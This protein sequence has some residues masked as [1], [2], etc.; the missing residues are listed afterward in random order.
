MGK[1]LD[2]LTLTQ[3]ASISGS[4][5]SDESR[6]DNGAKL[7]VHSITDRFSVGMRRSLNSV[8]HRRL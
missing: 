1:I 4:N 3:I 2:T 8:R 6:D 7:V 5:K